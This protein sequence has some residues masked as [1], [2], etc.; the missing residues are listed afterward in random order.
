MFS[1]LYSLLYSNWKTVL[2]FAGTILLVW[3]SCWIVYCRTVHPL[4]RVPG[5]FLASFSR[6]WIWKHAREGQMH[7][8]QTKLHQK[9]GNLVRI[10]PNELSCSDPAAIKEI[11]KNQN[12]LEKTDFYTT[13]TNTSFGKHKDNFSVTNEKEHSERRRIVNHVYSLSNVLKSEVYIDECSKLFIRKLGELADSARTIDLGQWLQMYA[14]DVIGEL[15]FGRMFGFMETESDYQSLIH[16]LDIL[17]PLL[18]EV[19]VSATYARPFIL[20]SAV[21]FGSVRRALKAIDHVTRAATSC[22]SKR[23]EELKSAAEGGEPPRRDLLQQLF[24]IMHEK[25]EKVDFGVPEL[26]Y[27]A[28]VA[29]FAGS[30]TT[31]I[32]MRSVFYHLSRSPAALTELLEE[33]DAAFPTSTHPLQEPIQYADAIKLPLLCATIKEAMRLHPSVGFTMP[34]VSPSPDGLYFNG[35]HIPPG[36]RIGINAHI[37]Q[38]NKAVFGG[39]AEIFRPQRWLVENTSPEKLR[40]MDRCMLNF[41]AGTR[42]CI[43]KNVSSHF[44]HIS[45]G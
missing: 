44:P 21:A 39:D 19:A 18:A 38:R 1:L 20:V 10:A 5:P 7:E 42:T 12:P 40:E 17:N 8:L 32:A 41:G 29:L 6:L 30:D 45:Q 25:G 11:Y 36:Y 43:G 37:V 23:Q 14:F 22:V 31:A 3:Q 34:R 28:Y 15:Y 16:S 2:A 24:G 4:A 9:H 27:E 35:V 26:Q 13:W 33:I